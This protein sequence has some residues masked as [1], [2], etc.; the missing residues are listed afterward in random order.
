MII[1]VDYGM[2]NL[3]SIRNMLK[4]AG[5]DSV[6]SN[7]REA[8]ENATKLILPGVGA[9]DKAMNNLK[10]L[11]LIQLLNRKV[12]L[13]KTPVLGICLG[14]QL[15]ANSS[16]EGTASGLGWIDAQVKKFKFPTHI[17]HKIPHMGWNTVL[18]TKNNF[19][20]K[21]MPH[22][23]LRYYFVHSYYFE[24]NNKLDVFGETYHG[25]TFAAAINKENIYG[26]QFHPEKSHK[27]GMQLLKNFI[28]I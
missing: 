18:D 22:K 17:Y 6:I 1:I 5:S 19:L 7:D 20:F 2:G 27:F 15:M 28:D 25:I 4:K 12:L 13:E 24:A 9:F 23:E 26:V 16:E 11:D 10:D 14:M 21:S 8:I 3:G